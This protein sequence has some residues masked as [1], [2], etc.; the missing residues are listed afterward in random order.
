MNADFMITVLEG[1]KLASYKNGLLTRISSA[2]KLER[3][4]NI[5]PIATPKSPTHILDP[6]ITIYKYMYNAFR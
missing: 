6:S 3:M 1:A 2:V 4:E 5:E